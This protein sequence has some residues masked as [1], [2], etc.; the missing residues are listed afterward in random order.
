[1]PDTQQDTTAILM[2]SLQWAPINTKFAHLIHAENRVPSGLLMLI[3]DKCL[4]S[5]KW[6]SSTGRFL[7][8]KG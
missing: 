6:F 8:M 1:M 4:F 2:Y 5:E 7:L 3:W